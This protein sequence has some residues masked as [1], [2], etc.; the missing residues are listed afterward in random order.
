MRYI[1]F[2]IIVVC[3][4]NCLYSQDDD[5]IIGTNAYKPNAAFYD[6]SDPKG[7]NM[8]VNL[9]GTV[10]LPGRYRVPVNTT[11]LDLISFS[12]GPAENSK[13][14]DIRIFRA[15]K[16]E[17]SKAEIIKLNYN[18]M[19]YSDSPGAKKQNPVLKSG[20]IVVV[21]QER[22]YSFREDISF[23][24]PIVTTLISVAILVVTLKK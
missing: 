24:L 2:I 8:E 9:W 11:F 20:D 15:L 17:M 4:F 7:V 3:S 21:R 23:I 12:G 18:D 19:L 16:D 22:R 13:L 1:L 5:L 10:K 6:L 14:D